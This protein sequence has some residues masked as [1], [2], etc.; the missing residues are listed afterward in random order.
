MELVIVLV[1]WSLGAA[2]ALGIPTFLILRARLS[3]SRLP[4]TRAYIRGDGPPP[5]SQDEALTAFAKAWRERGFTGADGL[6]KA[7]G[8][9]H[10]SWEPGQFFTRPGLW[11][12]AGEPLKMRGLTMSPKQI[13]VAIW[14]GALLGDVALF[15]ELTHVALWV[16][17]GEPDAD[18][19]GDRYPGWTEEHDDMIRELKSLFRL[20]TFRAGPASSRVQGLS[21]Q[22]VSHDGG[23]VLCG[24]C[25][26]V[27]E[28]ASSS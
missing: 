25:A 2:A 13:I 26:G 19:K 27:D 14:D 16:T 1:L 17:K 21:L 20:V 11:D 6:L 5:A 15:H 24:S 23:V 4:N 10:I 28:A 8:R 3:W 22:S 18:H 12:K 7:F 9:L